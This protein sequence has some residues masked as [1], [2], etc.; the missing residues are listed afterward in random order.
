MNHQQ[1]GVCGRY[2]VNL[3]DQLYQYFLTEPL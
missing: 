3:S 1:N 2:V